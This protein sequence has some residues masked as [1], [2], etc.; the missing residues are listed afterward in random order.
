MHGASAILSTAFAQGGE[1]NA[2]S[3]CFENGSE[4]TRSFEEMVKSVDE[5]LDSAD[6]D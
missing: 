4:A 5:L 6:F 2:T 3:L 1:S